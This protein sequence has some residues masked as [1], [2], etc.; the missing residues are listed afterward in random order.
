VGQATIRTTLTNA[1]TTPQI[2]PA[3]LFTGPRGTGKT[4]TARIL[5]KSLNCLETEQPT[6]TPCGQC[7]SCRGIEKST[8]LD[9]TPTGLLIS[10]DTPPLRE[11]KAQ[12]PH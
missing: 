7:L 2:A 3:Y 6:P 8:S 5:A 9:Y 11:K 1:I 12:P 4:S 10:D